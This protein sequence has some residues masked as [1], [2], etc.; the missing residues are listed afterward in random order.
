MEVLKESLFP[1]FAYVADLI[2]TGP[3]NALEIINRMFDPAEQDNILNEHVNGIIISDPIADEIRAGKHPIISKAMN[4]AREFFK[5][6]LMHRNTL[7]ESGIES[8]FFIESFLLALI[9]CV[10]M[11]N[12]VATLKL[13]CQD[14]A[15]MHLGQLLCYFSAICKSAVDKYHI[16]ILAFHFFLE[17][18]SRFTRNI[19][20]YV[21]VRQ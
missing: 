5:K 9:D 3:N 11:T 14:V 17:I 20:V 12:R 21:N 13:L 16:A 6:Q 1:D 8:N 15:D 4:D 2:L 10:L 18:Q 19:A 7:F